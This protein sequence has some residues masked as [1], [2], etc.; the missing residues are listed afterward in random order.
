VSKACGYEFS[1]DYY[2]ACEL[3]AGHEGEH[4]CT[5]TWETRSEEKLSGMWMYYA[6]LRRPLKAPEIPN[7][8]EWLSEWTD[9]DV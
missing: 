1:P 3:E 6:G 7:V 9:S 8:G 4:R 5:V 2:Y